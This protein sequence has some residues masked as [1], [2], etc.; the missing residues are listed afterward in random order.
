MKLK[1]IF[2]SITVVA[3]LAII[4]PT[5]S[6]AQEK[7]TPIESN[8]TFVKDGIISDS[9]KQTLIDKLGM[10]EVSVDRLPAEILEQ[11]L[12]EDAVLLGGGIEESYD[13][14]SEGNNLRGGTLTQKDMSLVGYAYSTA[15]DR[16]GYKKINFI[17]EFDWN[18]DPLQKWKDSMSI[19][20]PVT[21]LF[22]LPM[23]PVSGT[24]QQFKSSVNAYNPT[25]QQWD[26]VTSTSPADWEN[27]TGVGQHVD[28]K[29]AR[30]DHK[31]WMQQFAYVP[32]TKSGYSNVKFR[33]AHSVFL[34]T[35]TFSVY[36]VGFAVT[37][38]NSNEH[39]DYGI[40][41]TW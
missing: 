4:V 36:P 16:P 25:Y 32:N 14:Q 33:Y 27:G 11:L 22:V 24:V 28:L 13:L 21:N 29:A 10:L 8:N 23:D 18:I 19:G 12:E 41:L 5:L 6:F 9:E 7:V 31:G 26:T 40:E 39:L 15:S 2:K 20:W 1:K 30:S 35:P 3:S 37:P 17:L 34:L 38:G